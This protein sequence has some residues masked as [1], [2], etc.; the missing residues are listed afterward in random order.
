MNGAHIKIPLGRG[1]HLLDNFQED[2]HAK[3]SLA[4]FSILAF[5]VL[6]IIPQKVRSKFQTTIH[7]PLILF[8]PK[9]NWYQSLVLEETGNPVEQSSKKMVEH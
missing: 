3:F 1:F 2:F 6:F 4:L 9:N 8:H 7:P 5:K